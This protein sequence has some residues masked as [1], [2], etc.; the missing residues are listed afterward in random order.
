LRKSTK[1]IAGR[2]EGT[3]S[4]IFDVNHLVTKKKAAE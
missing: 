1:R 3:G 4:E 2:K